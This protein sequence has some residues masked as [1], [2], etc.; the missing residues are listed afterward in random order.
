MSNGDDLRFLGLTKTQFLGV[1]MSLVITLMCAWVY[2]GIQTERLTSQG[3]QTHSALCTL[4]KDYAQRL[5]D[6][7]S[8][9]SMTVKQRENKFGPALGH[10]P[11]SVIHQTVHNL[12]LNL[13]A[14][15]S[16]DC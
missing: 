13:D 10:I 5:E 9:L 3:V 1:L 4:K 6:N 12:Q 15:K 16:L 7:Q 2:I 11:E 8:F 14:L